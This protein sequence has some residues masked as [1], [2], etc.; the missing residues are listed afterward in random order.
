M[1]V[2]V[3]LSGLCFCLQPFIQ[4]TSNLVA[5]LLGTTL[6]AVP[7]LR[8]FSWAALLVWLKMVLLYQSFH[9]FLTAVC[10][11]LPGRKDTC[12]WLSVSS[13]TDN[14]KTYHLLDSCS[15]WC[16][17]N[18]QNTS[19]NPETHHLSNQT[20]I[21]EKL[22]PFMLYKESLLKAITPE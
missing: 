10:S 14:E 2:W 11:T 3:C 19:P 15:V 7:S 18:P 8:L 13:P 9:F 4:S 5:V 17:G 22:S 1:Q 12:V 21:P 6:S 20:H 16:P